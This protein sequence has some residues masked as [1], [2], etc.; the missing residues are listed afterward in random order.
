MYKNHPYS[1]ILLSYHYLLTTSFDRIRHKYMLL[2]LY[3]YIFIA[4][5]D[6]YITLH[7]TQDRS[8]IN[9]QLFDSYKLEIIKYKIPPNS[10]QSLNLLTITMCTELL[11]RLFRSNTV[12][13]PFVYYQYKSESISPIAEPNYSYLLA[14][15]WLLTW[16]YFF[17]NYI[18]KFGICCSSRCTRTPNQVHCYNDTIPV[19][20]T[21]IYITILFKIAV[22]QHVDSIGGQITYLPS[23]LACDNF[24]FYPA[25]A[26]KKFYIPT[27][28]LRYWDLFIIVS[29]VI[30]IY[31]QIYEHC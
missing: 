17:L 24:F 28:V 7:K 18:Y 1:Y 11:L 8:Q 13:L 14:R 30:A 10:Q 4:I 12:P 26:E 16:I 6:T 21:R 2:Q 19:P 25:E 23:R 5:P 27:I 9:K 3:Y 22:F 29:K 31:Y 20:V 15:Y